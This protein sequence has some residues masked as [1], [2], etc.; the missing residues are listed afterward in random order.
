MGPDSGVLLTDKR[1]A[2]SAINARR[3]ALAEAMGAPPT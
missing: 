1:D 3:S 2:R